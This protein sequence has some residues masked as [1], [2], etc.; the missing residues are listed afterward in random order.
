MPKPDLY[1]L[2][3]PIHELA[4]NWI[5]DGVVDN[6][7]IVLIDDA[8]E[9]QGSTPLYAHDDTE[10]DHYAPEMSICQKTVTSKLH[11]SQTINQFSAPD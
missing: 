11:F 8:E 10:T 3:I 1:H 9:E 6:Y 2:Q 5:E 7:G 4:R